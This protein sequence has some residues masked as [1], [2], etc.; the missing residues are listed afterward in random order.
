M[1]CR[2]PWL[3]LHHGLYHRLRKTVVARVSTLAD[4]VPALPTHWPDSGRLGECVCPRIGV[5]PNSLAH[6]AQVRPNQLARVGGNDRTQPNPSPPTMSAAEAECCSTVASARLRAPFVVIACACVLVFLLAAPAYWQP[7]GGRPQERRFQAAKLWSAIQYLPD[8]AFKCSLPDD[9][10]G[11]WSTGRWLEANA[12]G[13]H[14]AMFLEEGWNQPEDV[15]R[16]QDIDLVYRG[17]SGRD[18]ALLQ[19][20]LGTLRATCEVLGKSAFPEGGGGK[21]RTAARFANGTQAR[22]PAKGLFRGDVLY[23]CDVPFG[24]EYRA[25][26]MQTFQKPKEEK[27]ATGIPSLLRL[28]AVLDEAQLP[29]YLEGGSVLGYIRNCG[30]IPGDPDTGRAL[31]SAAASESSL[32]PC[33]LQLCA[34][35]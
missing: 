34:W 14:T 11:N 6:A 12:M 28:K 8:S 18:L 4:G 2:A 33:R 25:G 31:C 13:Q 26:H 10:A 27:E 7:P 32:S 17:V 9:V 5:S 35:T 15:M 20:L 16:I 24:T 29:F 21:V 3:Q 1:V 19:L 30:I 23:T 22:A